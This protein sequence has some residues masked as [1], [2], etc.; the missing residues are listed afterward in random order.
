MHVDILDRLLDSPATAFNAIATGETLCFIIDQQTHGDALARLYGAGDPIEI[1]PLYFGTEFA[2][3][4]NGPLWLQARWGSALAN[5]AAG[6]CENQS[7]GIAVRTANPDKALAHARWLLRANDGSGGQSLL[8]YHKPSLWAALSL[9]SG[10]TRASPLGPW[11]NVYSPAPGH[12]CETPHSWLSW[13]GNPIADPLSQP[14]A[15]TLPTHLAQDE[16][17][18]DWLYWLDEYFAEYGSPE[19]PRLPGIIANLELLVQSEIVDGNHLLKLAALTAAAP[20]AAQPQ[21]MAILQTTDYAFIKVDRLL[22]MA[23]TTA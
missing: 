19:R 9:T 10:A 1:E 3:I 6:L 11:Q 5:C 15:F 23:G 22:E 7:G 12:F 16:R 13:P 21:A 4:D 8:S 18:L 20:F 2:S 17:R 14:S